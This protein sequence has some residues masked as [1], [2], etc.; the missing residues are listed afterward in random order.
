MLRRPRSWPEVYFGTVTRALFLGPGDTMAMLAAYF[1]ESGTHDSSEIIVV[2]GLVSPVF[3][4]ERLTRSWQRILAKYQLEDF[5]MVDCAHGVGAF[6]SWDRGR[7]DKL[8]RELVPVMTKHVFWRAW[9][10]IVRADYVQCFK[11][12]WR[13][14]AFGQAYTIGALGCAS[15][16]LQLAKTR[17][18]LI[19]YMFE[20]G[21][22]GGGRTTAMLQ[23]LIESGQKEFYR[24]GSLTVDHRRNVPAL[25][26]ADLHAYEVYKY[27]ADQLAG[28]PRLR[29]S[30]KE[31]LKIAEAGN[32]G[33][34]LTGDKVLRLVRGMR[35]G[36]YPIPIVLDRLNSQERV[37]LVPYENGGQP[38][39]PRGVE[40]P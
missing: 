2:A 24:M 40:L 38:Q 15:R 28:T 34:L 13:S 23:G 17:D 12:D 21:G 14:Q 33:Y 27:F 20:Q 1:D 16:I 35:N 6:K 8:V 30:F 39:G 7:R 31:L 22:R 37:R 36:E 11:R 9:T 25:Q 19:P 32:G 29:G 4:W 10:A 18:M 3:R 5:H 26:A